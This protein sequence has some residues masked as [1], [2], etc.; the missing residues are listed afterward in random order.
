[1]LLGD[2]M[3]FADLPAGVVRGRHVT[4]LAFANQSI[5]RIQRLFYGNAVIRLVQVIDIEVVRL[6]S[7]QTIFNRAKN[8]ALGKST[9][10]RTLAH[11]VVNLGRQDQVFTLTANRIPQQPLRFT[12]LIGVGAV[13]KIN[14]SRDASLYH[15]NGG[16]LIDW[17]AEGHCPQAES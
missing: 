14:T 4:N 9:F 15:A 13:E 1:M 3:H 7:P 17:F 10:I 16:R 8:S 12:V 6:E 5:H 11:L 2:P